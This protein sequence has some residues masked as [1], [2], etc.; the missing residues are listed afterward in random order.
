MLENNNYTVRLVIKNLPSG[1]HSSSM[2]AALASL[3]ANRQGKYGHFSEEL[4]RRSSYLNSEVILEIAKDTGLDMDRFINDMNDPELQ[5]N[6]DRDIQEALENNIRITPTIYLNGHYI[7]AFKAY[8][9]QK[10]IDQYLDS[11]EKENE[12]EKSDRFIF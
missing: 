9:I 4:Y 7:F 2:A 8:S 6:I 3:A 10:E 11:L 1:A 12:K 5:K